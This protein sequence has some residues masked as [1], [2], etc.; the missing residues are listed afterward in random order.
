MAFGASGLGLKPRYRLCDLGGAD[1]TP[2]SLHCPF[3]K[4]GIAH[5]FQISR[6]SGVAMLS[7]KQERDLTIHVQGLG[8]RTSRVLGEADSGSN[9]SIPLLLLPKADFPPLENNHRR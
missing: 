5:T 3:R 6:E 8:Y 2:Q 1:I 7:A 4:L 9:T